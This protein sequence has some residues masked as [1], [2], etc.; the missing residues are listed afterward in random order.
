MGEIERI[1]P[2]NF[3]KSTHFIANRGASLVDLDRHLRSFSDL[4][5]DRRHTAP[6]RI[7]DE[8]GGGSHRQQRRNN[9]VQWS[10]IAADRR[11]QSEVAPR[12]E[13]CCTG[14]TQQA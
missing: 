10:A 11:F 1:E 7:A 8:A 6:S 12:A 13:D 4:V 14:I 2:E 9:I 5:E 3:A